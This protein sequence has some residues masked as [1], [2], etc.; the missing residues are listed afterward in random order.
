MIIKK[1]DQPG[2]WLQ[3]AVLLG[4]VQP[5]GVARCEAAAA[6]GPLLLQAQG[7]RQ[8]QEWGQHQVAEGQEDS[9]LTVAQGGTAVLA[10]TG[11]ATGPR[12][13]TGWWGC[14]EKPAAGPTKEHGTLHCPVAKDGGCSA[15][16]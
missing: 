5:A 6:V 3:L 14:L 4:G 16:A 8:E 1:A 13:C 7:Q 11:A 9:D 2:V 12:A 15:P 10:Q